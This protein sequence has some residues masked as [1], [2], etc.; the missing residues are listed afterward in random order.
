MSSA[1]Y[2][3]IEEMLFNAGAYKNKINS[4]AKSALTPEVEIFHLDPDYPTGLTPARTFSLGFI[5]T[6]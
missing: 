6:F 4:I 5:T 2:I 3:D 1:D